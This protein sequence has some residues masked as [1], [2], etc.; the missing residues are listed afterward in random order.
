MT[1]RRR[2]ALVHIGV[3][4]R[5]GIYEFRP[6]ETLVVEGDKPADFY[7]SRLLTD[8]MLARLLELAVRETGSGIV[9]IDARMGTGK[10]HLIA[11]LAARQLM[12]ER[13]AGRVFKAM[14]IA[15]P[16][17]RM[18]YNLARK[19]HQLTGGKAKWKGYARTSPSIDCP[20]GKSLALFPGDPFVC[21]RCQVPKAGKGRSPSRFYGVRPVWPIRDGEPCENQIFWG[22][23]Y[24]LA[25]TG[26]KKKY[27]GMSVDLFI[28]T[29]RLLFNVGLI[30][31][32]EEYERRGRLE[33]N[34]WLLVIDEADMIANDPVA[35]YELPPR[36]QLAYELGDPK[37]RDAYDII[38][39]EATD[40][41]NKTK[42]LIALINIGARLRDAGIKAT[43]LAYRCRRLAK[44][45]PCRLYPLVAIAHVAEEVVKAVGADR[46]VDT[47]RL[48][49]ELV[50]YYDAVEERGSR[51]AYSFLRAE[52]DGGITRISLEMPGVAYGLLYDK[53]WPTRYKLLFTGT[54]AVEVQGARGSGE[55]VSLMYM[56][57]LELIKVVVLEEHAGQLYIRKREKSR[58]EGREVSYEEAFI[59]V[60]GE[61]YIRL[62][63]ELAE[64]RLEGL[65]PAGKI[66]VVT[67]TRRGMKM[68][69]SIASGEGLEC[70]AAAK[71]IECSDGGV[72]LNITYLGSHLRGA[73]V[74]KDYNA[75]S[76]ATL[77]PHK[78]RSSA[79]AMVSALQA[80]FRVARSPFKSAVFILSNRLTN[81]LEKLY[82]TTPYVTL[83]R[84]ATRIPL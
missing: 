24:K 83:L 59:D 37:L 49:A 63:V 48:I 58:A 78:G 15:V 47:E 80:L 55:S 79:W 56:P 32:W 40:A 33:N 28:V 23:M 5:T 66:L 34:R 52:R 84:G 57:G 31:Q 42:G 18:V 64:G 71:S 75:A 50:N 25:T 62:L 2:R 10:T 16:D 73:N 27:P 35:E 43:S 67:S 26:W 8:D 81:L 36:D 61:R 13:V 76:V 69:G 70:R 39:G 65:P 6:L 17:R 54:P 46:E 19:A 3:A 12:G 20:H 82:S 51:L 11:E 9:E 74:Y 41:G 7:L 38:V 68:L 29:H 44:S 22:L 1:R 53:N 21:L 72:Y 14:L 45:G 60:Y 4:R 77:G 30:R